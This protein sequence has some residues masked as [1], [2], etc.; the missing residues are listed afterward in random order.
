MRNRLM[1]VTAALLLAFATLAP[2]Q[3][4]AQSQEQPAASAAASTKGVFDVGFRGTSVTGDEARYERY[5]DLQN[6]AN[7]NL[8]FHKQT[9]TYLFGADAK[10]VGYRDQRYS[11]LYKSGKVNFSFL[12]DSLPL[13]YGY[14]TSTPWV[15]SGKGKWTLD[16]AARTAVQN[17]QAGIIGIPTTAALAA[18]ASIYRALAKPFEL[19]QKRDSLGFDVTYN[20]TSELGITAAVL[21]TAKSGYQPWGASFAFNNGNELPLP[22]DH[23]TNDI[24]IAAEWANQ[25]GMFRVAWEG[26]WFK[27][28]IQSLEWDNA[29][30]ITDFSNGLAPL[31]GPYDPSGYSNGNGPAF[32]RQS[33]FP[34]SSQNTVSFLALVKLAKRTVINGAFS[35]VD[36]TQ[37]DTLIPWTTNAVINQPLVWAAF[38][39]LTALERTTAEAK[40]RGVN[41]QVNF[42]SRPTNKVGISAKYRHNTHANISR[43]FNA[44]EYVRFDAVPEET[45]TESK[46]LD[47]V[48]DTVDAAISFSLM[49]LS[50]LRVG[51]GYDNFNRTGRAHSDM[52]DNIFRV[53]LDTTGNQYLVLRLG[54]EM[55][56]RKGFG[57]SEMAIEEGGSQPGLRFYDEAERDRNRANLLLTLMPASTVD[58]TAA[59]AYGKDAYKGPGLEFGLLDANTTGYNVGINFTPKDQVAFGA[60]FGRENF[61]SLQKSRNANPPPDPQFNDANRDWTLDNDEKVNNVDVYLD[62]MNLISKTDIK[63]GYLFSDSDNAYVHGGP[64]VATLRATLDATGQPTFQALPTVTNSWQ[65][66]RA[67]LRVHVSEKVGFGLEYRYEKLDV[68]DYATINLP[69][70]DRPRIDYLGGI[71]TGYGNRPYKGSTGF[72]RIMYFF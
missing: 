62:L 68:S 72:A 45:G 71:T 55:N 41:G 46:G 64:R 60:N 52:R 14:N 61:S 57:F 48:R 24:S 27:N 12:Y 13:N 65:Q 39:E 2:V 26:S 33:T 44:V 4:S 21:S 20:A 32:G 49:P 17:K 3:A 50:T 25:K 67:E 5:S 58:I 56:K 35:V 7:I 31:V 59:V 42:T 66:L 53:T 47:I 10:N 6:G 30:R 23:R 43:P 36:N 40:V 34:D 69:G 1:I 8:N 11:A 18:Q 70:T 28:Q 29:L 51:Y 22:L 63:F 54:Y 9:D 38:P 19:T 16:T 15:E 37:N